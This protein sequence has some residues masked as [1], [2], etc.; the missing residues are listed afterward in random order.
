MKELKKDQFSHV[1]LDGDWVYKRQHEF[2]T[3]NE[4][5]CLCQMYPSGY[6]PEVEKIDRDLIRTKYIDS[7]NSYIGNPGSWRDYFIKHVGSILAALQS[8]GIRH[9][10]LTKYAV[11]IGRNWHP[12]IID[13]SE[14]R[15]WSDPRPDKRPEGDKYW[16]TKTMME[17]VNDAV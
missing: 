13:F 4:Y 16:L 7:P 11:L 9:G 15:L 8:A 5:W 1:W 6:V 12:F 3:D 2:L 17:M 10:D 14:S